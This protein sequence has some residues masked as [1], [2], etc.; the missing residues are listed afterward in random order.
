MVLDNKLSIFQHKLLALKS[1]TLGAA[2]LTHDAAKPVELDQNR[3]GRLSRMDAIQGQAMAQA[4]ADRQ[5]Q[6][7]QKIEAALARLERGA[8]GRCFECDGFIADK[9]LEVDLT[10]EYCIECAQAL[11]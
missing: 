5:H 11:E 10:A 3:V 8:Y 1:E 4:S 2:E 9:R 6:L 7:L